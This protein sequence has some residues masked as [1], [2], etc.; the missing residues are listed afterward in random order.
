M[1]N[2]RLLKAVVFLAVVTLAAQAW[3]QP[4]GGR[5]RTGLFG[6]W[7]VTSEFGGR[8]MESIL[9]F[10]RD[11]DG[12][13][14]GQWIGFGGVTDLRN[15]Q[16]EEGQV[17]F[18]RE[19]RG[20]EGQTMTSNFTGRVE[21]GRL[22]GTVSSERGEYA[23]EGRRAPRRPR[24]AGT[25]EMTLRRDEREFPI[26]LEIRADNEGELTATWRSERGEMQVDRI[27]LERN[28]LTM[29]LQ[30]D[31]PE[32]PWKATFEGQLQQDGLSGT[33]RSE[34]GEMAAQGTRRGAALIGTWNLEATSDW[35]TRKQRLV[36][37]PDMTALYN[38]TPVKNVTL[39]GDNVRFKIAMSFG[40]RDFEM[41]FAGKIQNGKLTGEMTT[42]MG[43]QKIT[44]TK[45]VR[46][47]RRRNP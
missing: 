16:V 27:T 15:V 30:S 18:T 17:R 21:D 14:T 23:L 7:L 42:G 9:S 1:R 44:G 38:A 25:W 37:Y 43:S 31:N 36:V 34:R 2:Q 12:N 28:A 19:M 3:A 39:D 6:D 13:Q 11:Q 5:G 26:T 22:A 29:T 47:F 40:D 33:I 4:P 35:G 10:G 45:V 46:T 32:R 20:R 8:T 41:D 24:V